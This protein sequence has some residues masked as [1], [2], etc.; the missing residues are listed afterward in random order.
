MAGAYTALQ[1]A[2]AAP[3]ARVLQAAEEASSMHTRR[4]GL[5]GLVVLAGLAGCAAE[6]DS[7]GDCGFER[8]DIREPSCQRG[9]AEALSCLRGGDPVMPKFEVVDPEEYS[10]RSRG[11]PP[12]EEDTREV[13]RF[14]RG[15]SFLGLARED[16]MLE[17][18]RD[19]VLAQIAASYSPED[20]RVLV[21]D[22]GEP[23]D[24]EDAVVLLS[25]ELVHAMQDAEHDLGS[26]GDEIVGYDEYLALKAL[27][28]GEAT[29]YEIQTAAELQGVAR[30][31]IDWQRIYGGYQQQQI[32]A[33]M[34]DESPYLFA[35]VRFPYAFGGE[36]VTDGWLRD[37]HAGVRKLYDRPP[38]NTLEVL[39][40]DR[41]ESVPDR[42]DEPSLD[43]ER[44]PELDER[45]ELVG[46]DTLG[47]WLLM[48][49]RDRL[50]L[51]TGFLLDEQV[52]AWVDDSVAVFVVPDTEQLVL[53][54][55]VRFA[56]DTD[57]DL[58]E[59]WQ[60]QWEEQLPSP[61]SVWIDGSDVVMFVSDGG[62]TFTAL[63]ETEWGPLP[64]PDADDE[65]AGASAV[66]SHPPLRWLR[67]AR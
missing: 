58:L 48:I 52:R 20:G 1:A 12:S 38:R 57:E 5:L 62:L 30:T 33:A 17:Q 19:E 10:E 15:L 9:T 21:I 13:E 56:R 54:W 51:V 35:T 53:S 7:P 61:S 45:F 59:Q 18:E 65:E 25:H 36:L 32:E 23:L 6:E 22:K 26:L 34:V 44:V 64:E 67:Q 60:A 49:A 16:A 3:A 28:E 66:R 43:R 37:R 39:L 40:R 8:C 47:A 63:P 11:E 14:L 27:V 24:S 29:H 46:A 31:R 2:P 4:W 50:G 42:S 41:S 55:R